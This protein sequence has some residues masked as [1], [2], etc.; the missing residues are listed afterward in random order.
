MVFLIDLGRRLGKH[1]YAADIGSTIVF[2]GD[3]ETPGDIV[4]IIK[5]RF[6]M[7]AF[8]R[9]LLPDFLIEPGSRISRMPSRFWLMSQ[10]QVLHFLLPGIS[11]NETKSTEETRGG[12]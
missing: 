6:D 12:R 7:S 8:I 4:F 5:F 10:L 11:E 9:P 2:K 3:S 1:C